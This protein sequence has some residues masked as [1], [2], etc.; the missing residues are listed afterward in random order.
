MKYFIITW[1][2]THS[3]A[4]S[5]ADLAAFLVCCPAASCSSSPADKVWKQDNQIIWLNYFILLHRIFI[6]LD[7]V[8]EHKGGLHMWRD[9]KVCRESKCWFYK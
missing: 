4:R 5:M 3:A 1:G 2:C 9:L 8:G 7:G 6:C